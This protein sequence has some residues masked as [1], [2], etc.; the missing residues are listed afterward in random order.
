MDE[1]DAGQKNS[2][3]II[4]VMFA[5]FSLLMVVISLRFEGVENQLNKLNQKLQA[6]SNEVVLPEMSGKRD[7]ECRKYVEQNYQVEAK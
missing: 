4:L 3:I 1:V 5:F 2:I 7:Q 6:E